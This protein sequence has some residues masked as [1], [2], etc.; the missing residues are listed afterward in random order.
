MVSVVYP[1]QLLCGALDTLVITLADLCE[2]AYL[3]CCHSVDIYERRDFNVEVGASISCAANGTQWLREWE[4]N[5]PDMKPVILVCASPGSIFHVIYLAS[6]M[7]LVMRDWETGTILNQY[8]LDNYEQEWGNVYNMLHRQD[9]HAT[10]LQTATSP[11]G[12]GTPCSVFID[13]M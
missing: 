6:Q 4:V 13:H 10:L 3:C 11:E 7:K 9:M 1:L 2:F 5:I 8:N 12:K